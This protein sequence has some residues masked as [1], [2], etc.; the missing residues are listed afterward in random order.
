MIPAGVLSQGNHEYV[1]RIDYGSLYYDMNLR[2]HFTMYHPNVNGNAR[3]RFVI[4]S[5][6]RLFGTTT[7]GTWPPG[8]VLTLELT[9]GIIAGP[10]GTG[11]QGNHNSSGG[12][13]GNG[14]TGLTVTYP[15]SINNISG[16]IA[17]G[18]GGG[19]GGG[20]GRDGSTLIGNG[21]GGGG[22]APNG[23]GGPGGPLTMWHVQD[24]FGGVN[25]QGW[26]GGGSGGQ[27]GRAEYNGNF[28]QGGR[29]GDG[30]DI[31]M[32][33]DTGGTGVGKDF[34]FGGAGG[35]VGN[36]IVGESMVTWISYG[37]LRGNIVP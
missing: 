34:Y 12:N 37:D 31:G 1:M 18:A 21:G 27:G 9:G 5:G 20:S 22:G 23:A 3:V 33:G 35:A 15:I 19:G 10:G 11:G 25:G 4:E 28:G 29:G 13:G 36:A 17:G 32:P 8:F 2:D 24:P 7:T 16:I 14:G 30:G 26:L 6:G